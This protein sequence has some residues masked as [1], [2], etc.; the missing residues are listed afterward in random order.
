M[1]KFFVRAKCGKDVNL[2]TVS[3]DIDNDAIDY[4]YLSSFINCDWIE[5]V[6]A[7]KLRHPYILI[8]DEEGLLKQNPIVNVVATCLYNSNNIKQGFISPIS[9][10]VLVAK[11][12]PDGEG[13]YD[14]SSLDKSDVDD[15]KA[16]ITSELQKLI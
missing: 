10:D 16:I 13:A 15:V 7:K 6:K 8:V 2:E 11:M 14:I 1:S 9:G 4:K 5:V 3:V 12:V